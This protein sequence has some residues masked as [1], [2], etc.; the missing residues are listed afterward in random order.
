MNSVAI[1]IALVPIAF[2]GPASLVLVP[3][4]MMLGP[5]TFTR[6]AQLVAFVIRLPAVSP[7]M[8]DRFMQFV[9]GVLDAPLAALIDLLSRLSE[10]SRRRDRRSQSRHDTQ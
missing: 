3:P 1:V 4:A 8:L 5:A 6:L 2:V 9:L 10:G 7:V